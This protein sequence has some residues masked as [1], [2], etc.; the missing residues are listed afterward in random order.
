MTPNSVQDTAGF[1]ASNS[2]ISENPN[3]ASQ[4][5]LLALNCFAEVLGAIELAVTRFVSQDRER[6]RISLEAE[7]FLVNG[8][9]SSII[10]LGGNA[11]AVGFAAVPR[12][13]EFRLMCVMP[14]R[15]QGS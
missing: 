1:V 15:S 11:S 5:L 4:P 9:D 13:L 8:L 7:A 10:F 14:F 2:R 12:C 3:R 6:Q